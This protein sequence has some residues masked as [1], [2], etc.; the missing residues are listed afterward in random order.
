MA[1]HFTEAQVQINLK[2]RS[3]EIK[4]QIL[5]C[6]TG[7]CIYCQEHSCEH[8]PSRKLVE[9]PLSNDDAGRKETKLTNRLLI[10]MKHGLLL[11][12]V[13]GCLYAKRRCSTV[14]YYHSSQYHI[15]HDPIKIEKDQRVIIFDY[16]AFKNQFIS[17]YTLKLTKSDI[18]PFK[19]HK[20]FFSFGQRWQPYLEKHKEMGESRP[21]PTTL[22]SCLVSMSLVPLNAK[23][24]VMDTEAGRNGSET[25]SMGLNQNFFFFSLEGSSQVCSSLDRMAQNCRKKIQEHEQAR[26]SSQELEENMSVDQQNPAIEFDNLLSDI[27]GLQESI[28]TRQ[29]DVMQRQGITQ[30]PHFDI[31]Q[32]YPVEQQITRQQRI[33]QL[34]REFEEIQQNCANQQLPMSEL[35]QQNV[36]Q[37]QDQLGTLQPHNQQACLAADLGQ[38]VQ[39]EPMELNHQPMQLCHIE[40]QIATESAPANGEII[41]FNWGNG[42]ERQVGLT[43]EEWL[44]LVSIVQNENLLETN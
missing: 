10:G 41:Y 3:T 19:R 25:I 33:D 35:G 12:Y 36:A 39:H 6:S 4:S 13:D 31:P 32:Q 11:E 44:K 14:I 15:N 37:C 28:E 30:N 38:H 24:M 34:Q 5:D 27:L 40:E 1:D 8:E 17:W 23:E 29:N 16:P 7:C 20:I 21:Q 26:Q 43:S 9:L 42:T 22:D 18:E 2:Y